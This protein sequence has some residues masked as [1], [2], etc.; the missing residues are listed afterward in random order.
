MKALNQ[1]PFG[2]DLEERKPCLLGKMVPEC[3]G[4]AVGRRGI[5]L[6]HG[7]LLVAVDWFGFGA[8]K[9]PRKEV[10]NLFQ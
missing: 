10:S 4:L 1:V 5:K 6:D 7:D 9:I 3:L 8:T 2:S